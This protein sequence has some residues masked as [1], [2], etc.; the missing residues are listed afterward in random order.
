ME[1]LANSHPWKLLLS[2][3][4]SSLQVHK[5]SRDL[6]QGVGNKPRKPLWITHN[7]VL[8]SRNTVVPYFPG[9]YFFFSQMIA[10]DQNRFVSKELL[11]SNALI[12]LRYSTSCHILETLYISA[13]GRA[14]DHHYT[15]LNAKRFLDR[16]DK[17]IYIIILLFFLNLT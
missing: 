7:K 9:L 12:L 1:L 8:F 6:Q 3:I 16:H 10:K 13:E 15:S 2:C 4:C 5:C 11:Q 14:E 17:K